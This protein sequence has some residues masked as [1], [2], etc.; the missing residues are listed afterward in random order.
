MYI[1]IYIY[2]SN[3]YRKCTS[4][5]PHLLAIVHDIAT[6]PKVVA[7]SLHIYIY[8]FN[9]NVFFFCIDPLHSFYSDLRLSF[10]AFSDINAM[11]RLLHCCCR[12][13]CSYC[14]WRAVKS[15]S[16][17]CPLRWEMCFATYVR[18]QRRC[19]GNNSQRL[20]KLAAGSV[21][22]QSRGC[23]RRHCKHCWPSRSV[24]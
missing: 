16:A 24:A 15:A 2:I 3:R 21:D 7:I 23:K 1:H 10:I 12:C 4:S 18:H 8:V 17:C 11:W 6:T 5:I 20:M 22:H 19:E 9:H 13:R 14:W